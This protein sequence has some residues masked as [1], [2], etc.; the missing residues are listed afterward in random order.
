MELFDIPNY[1]GYKADKQG[2][3]YSMIPQGCRNRF[4][5]NKWNKEPTLLKPRILPNGY[6][7]VYLRNDNTNKREDV[8]VHRIIAEL[9]L[10][11]PEGKNVINH[12]DCNTKNNCI[13]NLEWVT[14]KEN[15][16]YAFEYG[17]MS[18][19]NEGRFIHK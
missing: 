14:T 18:R 4:D 7:R 11:K 13:D 9:F 8:Y 6:L 3:I 16:D 1:T 12:K 10:D 15:V 17:Y 5:R 2:N 19:D